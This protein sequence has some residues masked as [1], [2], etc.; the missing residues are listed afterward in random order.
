MG[1]KAG[2]ASEL[3]VDPSERS[4]L[5]GP[6]ELSFG[7]LAGTSAR[8]PLGSTPGQHFAPES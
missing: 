5:S 1:T 4:P 2:S 3:L 7:V 8:R 6:E